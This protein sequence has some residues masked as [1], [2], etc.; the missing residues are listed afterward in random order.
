ME[1]FPLLLH[2]LQLGQFDWKSLGW[3][4]ALFSG[5]GVKIAFVISEKSKRGEKIKKSYWIET[6]C[7]I[8]ITFV[9]GY[10]SR[11][12][13]KDFSS[14][15]DIQAGIFALEG[16]LGFELFKI[17][18]RLLTNPK[19]WEKIVDAFVNIF[20]SKYAKRNQIDLKDSSNGESNP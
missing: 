16:V 10:H 17:F 11:V 13:I 12:M 5:F 3:A 14:S 15:A 7:G 1:N 6:A 20:L 9:I 19:L 8:F 2:L 4:F 18:Y